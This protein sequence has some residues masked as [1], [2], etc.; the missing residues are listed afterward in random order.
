ME[1]NILK[2]AI[3]GMMVGDALG[4]PYTGK[5]RTDLKKQPISDLINENARW[6]SNTTLAIYLTE[7]LGHN[8]DKE[9]MQILAREILNGEYWA[10][11]DQGEHLSE[12]VRENLQTV[13]AGNLKRDFVPGSDVVDNITLLQIVPLSVYLLNMPVNLRFTLV[14]QVVGMTNPYHIAFLS[15]LYLEELI[16]SFLKGE[17]LTSAYFTM[18]DT[19]PIIWRNMNMNPEDLDKLWRLIYSEIWS[20]PEEDIRSSQDIVDTLEAAMWVIMSSRTYVEAVLKA[21]NLGGDTP[22]LGA[23]VG[24]LAG[25]VFTRENIPHDW[26]EK[27]YLVEQV[28][29][30]IDKIFE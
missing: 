21:V 12:K 3:I 29:R 13:I 28:E 2:D 27:V 25:I 23:L 6:S 11:V 18:Q 5:K 4:Y 7:A 22:S 10:L 1:K 30:L 16:R 20:I 8:L 14:K 24:A 15:A 17:A 19:L 26:I 9:I